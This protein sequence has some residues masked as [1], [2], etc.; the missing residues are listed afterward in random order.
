MQSIDFSDSDTAIWPR[1]GLPNDYWPVVMKGRAAFVAKGESI[2][3]HGG[4]AIEEVV[5]PY[6]RVKRGLNER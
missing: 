6:I 4:I 3:G 1:T 2:V 5:V